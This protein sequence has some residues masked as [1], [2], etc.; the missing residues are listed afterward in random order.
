V[1]NTEASFMAQKRNR[2]L[3]WVGVDETKPYAYLREAMV[4]NLMGH[5][6]NPGSVG[7][8]HDPRYVIPTFS[9]LKY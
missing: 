1:S 7:D 2:K 6:C 5:I 4:S 3:S 8:A 9:M